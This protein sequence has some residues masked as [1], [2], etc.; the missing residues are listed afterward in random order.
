MLG[1]QTIGRTE[2]AYSAVHCQHGAKA[3]RI[4]NVS[5]GISAAV[6]IKYNTFP[7]FILRNYPCSFEMFKRVF[8][9]YDLLL[10]FPLHQLAYHVLPP[11]DSFQ[12]QS[13]HQRL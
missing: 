10:I 4:F 5:A 11:A 3:C 7:A 1:S 12:G 13:V 9:Q 2:Y 8:L 6:Q